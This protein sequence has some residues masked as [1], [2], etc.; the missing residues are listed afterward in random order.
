MGLGTYHSKLSNANVGYTLDSS[1]EPIITE[2][3]PRLISII[4]E[5]MGPPKDQLQDG[6]REQLLELVGFVYSKKPALI[7]EHPTLMAALQEA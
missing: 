7:Q 3:T 5:V 1:G 2:L 6:T 4:A